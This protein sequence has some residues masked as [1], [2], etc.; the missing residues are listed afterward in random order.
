[1]IGML[2]DLNLDHWAINKCHTSFTIKVSDQIGAQIKLFLHDKTFIYDCFFINILPRQ[3]EYVGKDWRTITFRPD[4]AIQLK[5]NNYFVFICQ[6]T[7][8]NAN[9]LLVTNAMR[10]IRKPRR[11]QEVV[12]SVNMSWCRLVI[13]SYAIPW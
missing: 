4:H 11:D 9:M 7:E 8:E 1:M 5:K 2:L 6:Q 13:T 3:E 12:F 10:N